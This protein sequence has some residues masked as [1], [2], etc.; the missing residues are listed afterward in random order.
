MA[1]CY[2]CSQCLDDTKERYTL[3]SCNH[4]FHTACLIDW[5]SIRSTTVCPCC[6]NEFCNNLNLV[7]NVESNFAYA[8][9]CARKR[10]AP[11]ALKRMYATYQDLFLKQK[12]NSMDIRVFQLEHGKEYNLLR[13]KKCGLRRKKCILNRKI[14]R[15]KKMMCLTVAD[16]V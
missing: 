10:D 14:K 13:K 4:E 12:Q 15:L 9:R 8:S 2:I 6:Y 1:T 3:S 16:N 7:P 11:K 5:F